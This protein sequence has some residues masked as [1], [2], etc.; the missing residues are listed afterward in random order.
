MV[1]GDLRLEN[2]L[3]AKKQEL[4]DGY[5]NIYHNV[6]LVDFRIAH[7]LNAIKVYHKDSMYY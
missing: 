1:H 7:D 4:N 6:K 3:I 2:V 5:D